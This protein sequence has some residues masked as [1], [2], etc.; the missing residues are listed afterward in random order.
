MGALVLRLVCHLRSY[1]MPTT[2][3]SSLHCAT[4][5]YCAPPPHCTSLLLLLLLLLQLHLL[6][7]LLCTWTD[8]KKCKVQREGAILHYSQMH[9]Y[10]ALRHWI[11]DRHCTALH[12]GQAILHSQK[13][14]PSLD[15]FSSWLPHWCSTLN[16]LKWVIVHFWKCLRWLLLIALDCFA[17]E[18]ANENT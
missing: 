7:L 12:W 8:T 17:L 4:T 2:N 1:W 18:Q 10:C 9:Y 13:C 3:S 14:L 16:I 5:Y 15:L 6:L 11:I